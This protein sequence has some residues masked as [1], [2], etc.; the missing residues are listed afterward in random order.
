MKNFLS[1]KP[2]I[3]GLRGLAVICVILYHANITFNGYPLF[4]GGYIGVDIFFVISGFLITRIISQEIRFTNSFS[5]I[6]FLK[7]R[8]RR[9]FPLL[10]VV[11]LS[12]LI[13]SYFFIIPEKF[14]E[15]QYS[16]FSVI[17]Y[18]SN[19]YFEIINNTYA[20]KDGLENPFI[21]TWSLSVEEQ[22]YLVFPIVF[23]I[24][25]K[26]FKNY[27]LLIMFTIFTISLFLAHYGSINFS[28]LNFY[29]LHSRMWEFIA[30]STLGYLE[31]FHKIKNNSNSNLS[32]FFPFIGLS[33]IFYALLYFD[34]STLHP[35]LN[36]LIPVLGVCMI[37]WRSEENGIII[38]F[39][40]NKLIVWVGLISYSLYL[41]HYPIL[42]YAK[43]FASL[44]INIKIFLIFLSFIISIFS[45]HLI[46]K[47]FRNNE[48]KF[49]KII[50]PIIL[51]YVIIV[52]I[53][54][55]SIK[56]DGFK[57]RLPKF[58]ADSFSTIK[59]RDILKDEKNNVCYGNFSE[60]CSFNKDNKQ[61]IFLIG[62]SH[63]ASISFD[64]KEKLASKDY[65]FSVFTSGLCYYF[66]G[67]NLMYNDNIYGGCSNENILK[68]EKRILD[69]EKSIIILFAR[70]PVI[71]NKT[72]FDNKEGGIE[73]GNIHLYHENKNRQITLQETFIKS[74]QK[75]LNADHK[76]I[77]IY[78]FPEAG[79]NVRSELFN[80]GGKNILDFK[81]FFKNKDNYLTTSYEVFKQRNSSSYKMLDNIKH[82][83]V[84][85]IYLENIVCNTIVKSRCITHDE[86]N[87]FYEDDDHPSTYA[88]DIISERIVQKINIINK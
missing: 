5:F 67:F 88:A 8:I 42:I 71:L 58:L 15:I 9:I 79:F 54:I 64:L 74:V 36:T 27:F 10:L 7:R 84:F 65:Q 20:I 30:G 49:K 81:N 62:D 13:F 26:Y 39:L 12:C 17:F 68:I 52:T 2:E 72:W 19:I 18:F 25:L 80:R 85:R 47:P 59:T 77:L 43:L 14:L 44:T 57:N 16:I 66:P 31:I 63:A 3:D 4:K 83:N 78:P 32:K 55:I 41:W 35:S 23:Y 76:L 34:E 61:K 38:R 69:T 6:F 29:Y 46:E 1:Y 56:T 24:S 87:V 70:L 75:L 82:N 28:S 11:V 33:L 40:S 53:C 48:N 73:G 45:Y 21:H 37:I 60:G 22:F 86:N 50:I 51:L